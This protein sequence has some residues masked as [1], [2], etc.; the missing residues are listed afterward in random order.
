MYFDTIKKYQHVLTLYYKICG[1]SMVFWRCF[2]AFGFITFFTLGCGDGEKSST[3][4]T[5]QVVQEINVAQLL[6]KAQ[7]SQNAEN[8]FLQG[9]HLLDTQRFQDA[10]Q[11]YDKA[12]ALK[13]ESPATW[14]N[15]GNALISLQQY[16][17]ALASYNKAIALKPDKDEAWYN[18]GNVLTSLAQYEAALESYDKAIAIKPDKHEAWINRGIVLTKMQKYQSALAS[19][20]QAIVIQPN[21]H[22]I[23]Y[24]KACTYALQK[25]IALAIENLQKAIQL[26][27][28]KYKTLAKTDP[29]FDKIRNDKRFKAIIPSN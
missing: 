7:A 23:Y 15:R 21:K 27:P 25:N 6:T 18:R 26:A 11:A 19:Y 2:V 5:K 3:E 10:I 28:G 12:I 20:N 16:E 9:N 4:N 24:N 1:Y 14:I 17:A 22:Q 13:P 29:D 8:L